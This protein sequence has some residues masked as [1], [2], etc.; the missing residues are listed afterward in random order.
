MSVN[1]ISKEKELKLI[2]IYLYICDIY[3]SNLRS[4]FER[5]SN[6]SKPDFTDQEFKTIY[7][8]SMSVEQRLK[9]KQIHDFADD[10]LRSWFPLLPS[11][12]GFKIKKH[13]LLET[14]F[15]S[16]IFKQLS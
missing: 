6:N 4:A 15:C 16:E 2:C 8:Y 1:M 5:F 7:L 13:Q 11:Y 14:V 12:E 10:H 3:D 9:I